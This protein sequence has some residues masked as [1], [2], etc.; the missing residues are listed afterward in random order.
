MKDKLVAQQKLASLGA[1]SAGI[2]HEI[3]NPLNLIIN[4]ARLLE[5]KSLI[6][7]TDPESISNFKELV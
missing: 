2:A 3:K 6:N 5:D 1:L 7:N 4:A